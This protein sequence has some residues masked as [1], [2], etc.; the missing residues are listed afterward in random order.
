MKC[1]STIFNGGWLKSP[2]RLCQILIFGLL[3]TAGSP[4]VKARELVAQQIAVG[5]FVWENCGCSSARPLEEV[6][7][8]FALKTGQTLADLAL[9]L[10]DENPHVDSV[11]VGQ[12]NMHESSDIFMTSGFK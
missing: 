4:F 3:H 10:L 1:P 9:A 12:K 6:S 5:R 11:N 2:S 8:F 7:R